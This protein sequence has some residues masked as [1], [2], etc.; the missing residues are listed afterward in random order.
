[1]ESVNLSEVKRSIRRKE[2]PTKAI[3]PKIELELREKQI[4]VK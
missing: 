1:M 4:A 3:E 2:E